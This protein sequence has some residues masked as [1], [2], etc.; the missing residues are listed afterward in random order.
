MVRAR[1]EHPFVHMKW[2]DIPRNCRRKRDG[3]HHAARGIALIRNLARQADPVLRRQITG[4]TRAAALLGWVA[5]VSGP[6]VRRNNL[7]SPLRSLS[8]QRDKW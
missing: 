4:R 1:V 3:V 8:S 2:W 5:G 6:V 7:S